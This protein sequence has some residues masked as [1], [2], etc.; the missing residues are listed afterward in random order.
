MNEENQISYYSVLPATVRYDKE[1]KAAEKLLYS[2]VT[3]LTNKFG[4]CFANNRYFAKLYDVTTHTVSQWLS[5]LEKL[6]YLHIEIIRENTNEIKERRIY[7]VDAPYVQKNTYPYVLKSTY[8]MYKKVQ[9]N[10]IKYNIDDLFNLI[11]N[12]SVDLQNDFKNIL[13]KL[14]FN[15]KEEHLNYMKEEKINMIKN[16]IYVLYDLYINNFGSVLSKISRESLL[17]L[18]YLAEEHEPNNLL[19]YYKKSIIN[20]TS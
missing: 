16:I 4:F 7:I 12:N 20:N 17:N 9:Y 5:H 6:G 19:N 14:G 13:E 15:Y 3:S 10:N 2:E 11:I 18:Y 1:L 8:P